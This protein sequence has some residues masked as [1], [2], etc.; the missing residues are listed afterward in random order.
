MHSVS[1]CGVLMFITRRACA[2]FKGVVAI[3]VGTEPVGSSTI[4]GFNGET[5]AALVFLILY[6]I[7]FVLLLIGY[8]G[9]YLSW[10]SRYTL[11][12]FHVTVRLA[13]QATGLAFGIIGIQ[14]VGLLVAYFVL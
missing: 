6:A 5:I 2:V 14:N 8:I 1:Y 11:I 9:R 7:L 12:L 10:R 4:M 3:R 13:S